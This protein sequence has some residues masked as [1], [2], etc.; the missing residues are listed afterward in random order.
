MTI[1]F[2]SHPDLRLISP[3][4]DKVSI[5]ID[6]VHGIHTDLSLSPVFGV[7]K[8][9]VIH[10]AHAMTLP[11]QQALLKLVEEPPKNVLFLL[12]THTP[13]ILLPTILSRTQLVQYRI[14]SKSEEVEQFV[15][16]KN[17]AQAIS[18]SDEHGAKKDT[19]IAFIQRVIATEKNRTVQEMAIKALG[20]LNKNINAKLV[21]DEFFFTVV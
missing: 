2:N 13:H 16:P 12:I 21:L 11:A 20:L 14:E 1:V 4:E 10:P 19:A 5:S 3:L 17:H 8:V 6:Q 7:Q 15:M 18:M 9:V